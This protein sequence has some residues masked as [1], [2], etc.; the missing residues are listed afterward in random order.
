MQ[1]PSLKSNSRAT[2]R[3]LH[4]SRSLFAI[5]L[6]WERYMREGYWSYF[7]CIQIFMFSFPLVSCHWSG[8]ASPG[9]PALPEEGC[10]CFLSTRGSGRLPSCHAGRRVSGRGFVAVC[11]WIM[12]TKW[13]VHMYSNTSYV[14]TR[15]YNILYI[16]NTRLHLLLYG[17]ESI[18]WLVSGTAAFVLQHTGM[19]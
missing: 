8:H 19:F 13:E 14:V 3:S 1:L 2:K 15:V 4:C 9:K 16:C 11:E 6:E 12:L 7:V 5:K 10:G 18:V 17:R